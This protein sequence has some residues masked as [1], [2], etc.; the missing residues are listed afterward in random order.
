MVTQSIVFVTPP[1]ETSCLD[2]HIPR[3][4][5]ENPE[6][7]VYS[8]IVVKFPNST[9]F[10]VLEIV[11]ALIKDLL[12]E[13]GAFETAKRPLVGE[14]KPLPFGVAGLVKS[15]KSKVFPNVEIVTY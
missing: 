6:A 3:V 12:T 11:I 4:E 14:D 15:P 1:G 9:A 2:P 13:D 7:F 10:P 5:F 8:F